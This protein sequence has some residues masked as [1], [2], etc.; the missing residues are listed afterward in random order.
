MTSQC[1]NDPL[2]FVDTSSE[3]EVGQPTK[4]SQFLKAPSP[5]PEKTNQPSSRDGHKEAKSDH[6]EKDKHRDP[7][8]WRSERAK[9]R[10]YAKTQQK[11]LAL[12]EYSDQPSSDRD[13]R[14]IRRHSQHNSADRTELKSSRSPGRHRRH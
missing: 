10:E 1:C 2:I 5:T 3:E 14:D 7:Q 9:D 13:S 11:L 6:S 12:A 4:L 8:A